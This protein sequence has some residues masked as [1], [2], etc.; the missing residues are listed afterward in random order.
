M[1]NDITLM[2]KD[3]EWLIYNIAKKYSSYYNIEDLYQVGSIGII[4]AYKKYNPNSDIK[5]SSYVYKY[6]LGEIINYIKQ[7]R[8]IKISDEYMNIYKKYLKV[9]SLLTSKNN[10]EPCFSEICSF[11]EISEG[12]LINIIESISFTLSLD[13]ENAYFEGSIDNRKDIDDKI[14]LNTELDML[15]EFDRHIINYRYYDGYTQ[16]ETACL[17]GVSQVKVSREEKLILQKLKEKIKA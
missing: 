15:N 10:K 11:M 8:N 9:K 14:L 17:L 12:K 5:F 16:S 3:N 2:I 1:K 13:N 4:K 6:I 7:D